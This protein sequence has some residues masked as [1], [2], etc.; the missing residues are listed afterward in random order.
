[1]SIGGPFAAPGLMRFA[2]STSTYI[3]LKLHAL[4]A[5]SGLRTTIVMM[6]RSGVDK[7]AQ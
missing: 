5:T 3:V 7:P 2:Q 4:C 1:L 6:A